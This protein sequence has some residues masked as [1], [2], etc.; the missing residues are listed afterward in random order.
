MQMDTTTLSQDVNEF[1]CLATAH[2]NT[3]SH[4]RRKR[5]EAARK[6][7][8]TAVGNQSQKS[9]DIERDGPL[10]LTQSIKQ[11][12]HQHGRDAAINKLPGTEPADTK[13]SG[14]VTADSKQP[15]PDIT[16][17]IQPGGDTADRKQEGENLAVSEGVKQP[18]DEQ[19]TGDSK[20]PRLGEEISNSPLI[21]LSIELKLEGLSILLRMSQI[22]GEQK[23]LLAQIMQ[24]FKNNL[25]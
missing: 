20:R 12:S 13:Q 15:G 17:N 5:R 1:V 18:S 14:T 11:E 10:Q 8:L 23:D 3:W 19:T 25:K 24:Y 21:K 2:R 22:E 7:Q 16:G 6:A 4:S 9:V